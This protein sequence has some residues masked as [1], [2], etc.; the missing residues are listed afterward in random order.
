MLDESQHSLDKSKVNMKR[1]LEANLEGYSQQVMQLREQVIVEIP[2]SQ[3]LSPE[4]AYFVIND[5]KRRIEA[6]HDRKRALKSG[7]DIFGIESPDHKEMRD[8][9]HDLELAEQI[10]TLAREW[11]SAFDRWK[12]GRFNELDIGEME[13]AA[14][15]FNKKVGK[16]GR[17]IKRWGIWEQMRTKLTEFLQTMPL[18]QDLR[19]PAMRTRHWDALKKE[20]HQDFDE[21]SSEFT[22]EAVFSTGLNAVPDLISELS[23]N[24]NKELAIE[25]SLKDIE[26][27]WAG[28]EIEITRPCLCPR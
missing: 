2:T 4:E 11:T 27:R 8:T 20:I 12:T 21:A 6:V 22:L 16:L 24:A 9:E 10:W 7:L 5:F 1:D 28:I 18:I 14:G 3:E 25:E 13:T 23:A 15:Q 19:N 17:E 26:T